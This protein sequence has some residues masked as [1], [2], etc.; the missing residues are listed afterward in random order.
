MILLIRHSSKFKSMA[1]IENVYD[2]SVPAKCHG[3][4]NFIDTFENV[5]HKDS[6]GKNFGFDARILAMQC[7]DM[8]EVEKAQSGSNDRTMDLVLGLSDFDDVRQAF[9]RS[10]LLPVELKLNCVAFNLGVTELMGKDTHTRSYNLG[11]GFCATSVFLFTKNVVPHAQN[12]IHRWALGSNSKRMKEWKVMTPQVFN[13]FI[14]FKTDFP[15]VPQTDMGIVEQQIT[16]FLVSQDIDG[17]AAYIQENLRKR[18]ETYY[19]VYNM[20]EV[21]YVADKLKD[22]MRTVVDGSSLTD[23]EKEYLNLAAETI[24]G[25]AN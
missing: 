25:L 21:K 12:S 5:V 16:T 14:K 6:P 11:I 13:S 18:M 24:Y 9:S 19:Y 23:M 1:R 4:Q 22:I 3:V 17:C 7:I 10:Y 20:L 2:S 8:D 15:Y